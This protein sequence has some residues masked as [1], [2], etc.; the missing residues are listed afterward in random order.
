M[1]GAPDLD[2]A[3]VGCDR[4]D[5]PTLHRRGCDAR[6]RD[7]FL[8]HD[9]GRGKRGVDVPEFLLKPEVDVARHD[10]VYALRVGLQRSRAV[11]DDW[12]RLV[13]HFDGLDRV[14]RDVP[15]P[16][17]RHG[18]RLTD[19]AQLVLCQQRTRGGNR[20]GRRQMNGKP[21]TL[22]VY[23]GAAK[24]GDDALV[25]ERLRQLNAC[26]ARVCDRASKERDVQHLLRAQIGDK[27]GRAS[28]QRVVLDA[29]SRLS[30]RA[31]LRPTRRAHLRAHLTGSGAAASYRLK[32]WPGL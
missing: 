16:R 3:I 32:R 30:D 20:P 2:A 22:L 26:D 1:R 6:M 15:V 27:G 10:L 21:L 7:G 4:D 9:V 31:R 5:A 14:L 19:V 24:G 12:E 8:D 13:V 17:D 18:D 29:R 23:L 11:A 25:R 28:K